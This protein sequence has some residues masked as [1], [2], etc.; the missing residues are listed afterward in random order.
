VAIAYLLL[1]G[2]GLVA[3]TTH[4]PSPWCSNSRDGTC[5]IFV[6]GQVMRTKRKCTGARAFAAFL[7]AAE[8]AVPK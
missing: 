2:I 7:H 6:I 5:S 3:K 4:R 1:C 8:K